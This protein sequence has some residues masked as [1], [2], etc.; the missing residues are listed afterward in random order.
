MTAQPCNI[1]K[2][3]HFIKIKSRSGFTLIELL[4]V[5][6]IIAI[7]AGLLLPA[8]ASAKRKA[9]EIKCKSNLKQLTLAGFMYQTDNGPLL[10]DQTNDWV[11]AILQY[12]ANAK[13][14]E[15]CPTASTNNWPANFAGSQGSAS[16]P[17]SK[18][19]WAASYMFNGWLFDATDPNA[20]QWVTSQTS[21]GIKGLFGKLDN[22]QHPSQ[23][24]MF[25]D[26]TW[27]DGWPNGNKPGG[28][29]ATTDLYDGGGNGVASMMWRCCILRHG[30]PN[31]AGAPKTGVSVTV[32]Y[33]SGGVN[34]SLADGH[35]EYSLLDNLWSQYYWHAIS[36]PA[37]RPGLP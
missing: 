26:G 12:S 18:S 22:I 27:C 25:V 1:M 23:T 2:H 13:G 15:F 7:L 8:L 37:T 5:I 11:T 9:Q 36:V 17:W 31:A 33:R 16:Y 24:P 32:P 29:P 34:I 4:V 14:D 20:T 10:Y 28:D 3:R 19:G 35:V 6:A 21:I 30:I